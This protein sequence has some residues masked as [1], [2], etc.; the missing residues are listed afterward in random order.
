LENTN[1]SES[2]QGAKMILQV[3]LVKPDGNAIYGRSYETSPP[4]KIQGIPAHVKAC[5]VLYQSSSGTSR[6]RVYTLEQNDDLWAYLFFALFNIA[7][8][9]REL[10]AT[11]A[12]FL[13]NHNPYQYQ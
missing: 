5:A 13:Y 8:R 4:A 9:K 6:E 7:K 2:L 3:H 12:S 10:E 11:P 1:L